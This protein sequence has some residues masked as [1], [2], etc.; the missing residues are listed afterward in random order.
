MH[1]NQQIVERRP[2]CSDQIRTFDNV[3]Q[4]PLVNITTKMKKNGCLGLSQTAV[5]AVLVKKIQYVC[6]GQFLKTTE[7]DLPNFHG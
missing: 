6:L 4:L 7:K 3:H 2:N 5:A 1:F